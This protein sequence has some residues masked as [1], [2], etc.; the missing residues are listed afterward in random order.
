[1]GYKPSQS[2]PSGKRPSTNQLCHKPMDDPCQLAVH[3]SSKTNT[4]YHCVCYNEQLIGIRKAGTVML[5]FYV[6]IYLIYGITRPLI[7]S[8]VALNVIFC[9]IFNLDPGT[10]TIFAYFIISILI[11]VNT[12]PPRLREVY[13]VPRPPLVYLPASR[14][15]RPINDSYIFELHR[16][17]SNSIL[18]EFSLRTSSK[19]SNIR[20]VG[21][22]PLNRLD[23]IDEKDPEAD[24][25]GPSH[26]SDQVVV[27]VVTEVSVVTEVTEMTEGM[28]VTEVTAARDPMRGSVSTCGSASIPMS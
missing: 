5:L 13:S 28:E 17:G 2:S 18:T 7:H 3:H 9:M 10:P 11:H 24:Y 22:G 16:S 15:N 27:A 1:M 25:H 12:G 4:L 19:E 26:S 8:H 20:S 21:I 14:P 23:A 6:V